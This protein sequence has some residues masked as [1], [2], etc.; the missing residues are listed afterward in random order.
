MPGRLRVRMPSKRGDTAYFSDVTQR[1][2]EHG[3]ITGIIANPATGSILIRHESDLPS[4][5]QHAADL[6]LFAIEA[7]LD[8]TREIPRDTAQ[9]WGPM[10]LAFLGLS[11]VQL[12]RGQA[13]GPATENIW[14]AFGAARFLQSRELAIVF[15]CLALMQIARGRM[16]G[17]AV[18]L[19]FYG[20][21]A[22]QL[23]SLA[24]ASEETPDPSPA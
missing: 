2:S 18:S 13:L 16:F 20:L 12:L 9:L 21:I 15:G 8:P 23:R 10:S 6:E 7:V 3:G 19:L 11:A 5:V 14:Q 1:L 24:L 22:Q 17:S 4:I